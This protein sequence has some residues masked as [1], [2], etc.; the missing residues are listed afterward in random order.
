MPDLIAAQ[1]D[2][3]VFMAIASILGDKGST[4]DVQLATC[5]ALWDIC[6]GSHLREKAATF[7]VLPLLSNLSFSDVPAVRSVSHNCIQILRSK[8]SK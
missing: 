1:A 5:T 3:G 2:G 8:G 4:P 6:D 7:G